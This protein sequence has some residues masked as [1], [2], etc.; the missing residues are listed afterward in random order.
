M[1]RLKK[2]KPNP[3][4]SNAS[5]TSFFPS[6]QTKLT[7]GK[8]NDAHEKEADAM[9]NRIVTKN[10][11]DAPSS[12]QKKGAEEEEVQSKPLQILKK[13]ALE[14][15]EPSVQKKEGEE[16]ESIQQKASTEEEEESVQM[17]EK[18]KTDSLQ[19]RLKKK[20]GNGRSLP[21]QLRLEMNESFNA[22]FSS[23]RI[24]TDKEAAQLCEELGAQ[25]FTYG[26]DIYFNEGKFNAN[27]SE[28]KRLLAHELTHTLQQGAVKK[29]ED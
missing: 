3:I 2:K 18:T 26:N 25:A 5:E 22:D 13:A 10:T 9:A 16:E 19:S 20:K 29:K 28:G 15:K 17:K 24:H 8:T 14:E 12:I 6:V 4:V 11:L 23:V 21:K 7:V 27:S 1:R